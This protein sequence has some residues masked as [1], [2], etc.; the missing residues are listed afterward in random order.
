M[1]VNQNLLR[2]LERLNELDISIRS[3]T[4]Q[5]NVDWFRAMYR[6]R[7]P[8]ESWHSHT[9]VEIHYVAEGNCQ[10]VLEGRTIPVGTGEA[11]AIAPGVA[12]KFV[13]NGNRPFFKYVLSCSA[14]T[15]TSG[16]EVAMI[17]SLL[18]HC[19]PAAFTLSDDI[20]QLFQ[21]SLEEA[22]SRPL[23]FLTVIKSNILIILA[24]VSRHAA[25]SQPIRYAVDTRRNYNDERMVRIEEYILR[26]V[27]Q[28]I[29]AE[30]IARHMNLSLKQIGR[31]ARACCQA[32]PTTLILRA[33]MRRAKELLKNPLLTVGQIAEK[34]GFGNEYYFNRVF[35]RLEGMPPGKYRDS[36]KTSDP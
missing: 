11:I 19:V 27:E 34:L 14:V 33:K 32:T 22:V 26:N 6:T 28:R 3:D 23:G 12:H 13:N 7:V 31:I 18:N 36:M 29:S 20:R 9:S 30:S 2:F 17:F 25:Q 10:F 21:M 24:A 5:I 4:D 8:N 16:S 15:E 1:H 35:K